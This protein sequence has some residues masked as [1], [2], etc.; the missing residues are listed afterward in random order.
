WPY[1]ALVL[2][3]VTMA[4]VYIW[5]AEHGFASFLFQTK[6]RAD[7]ASGLGFV[8]LFKLLTTQTVLLAPPLFV[9]MLVAIREARRHLFLSC[10][11]VPA[12]VGFFLVSLGAL[13]KPN[14][15]M[16][17]YVTGSLLAAELLSSRWKK[18]NVGLSLAF[19]LLVA[20]EL[21]AYPVPIQSDDTWKGW[22]ALGEQVDRLVAEHPV[23]FAF[24]T[25]G[26]KTSAELRYYAK[27]P[28]Y[29]ANVVGVPGLQFDYLDTSFT[30][31]AGK[32][33]LFLDSDTVDLS[34]A[35]R[36]VIPSEV[37]ARFASVQELPPLIVEERGRPLRK[38]YAY[39]CRGYR[40]P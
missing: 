3:Q 23:A 24:S 27:T 2:A 25:D 34:A 37:Q 36:G 11:F 7:H 32:D 33:A 39:L 13:V 17:A 30:E 15:L 31:L 20:V 10:F 19:H 22:R 1:L 29:G 28:T 40:P 5:N 38:F 16:P 8:N 12:F 14:W 21:I 4:P 35:Q 18:L 9:A 26:Y 6:D